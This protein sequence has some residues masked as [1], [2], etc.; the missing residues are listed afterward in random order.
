[1]RGVRAH[2]PLGKSGLR[3]CTAHLLPAPMS[4]AAILQG[5]PRVESDP[6]GDAAHT[7]VPDQP[8]RRA[9]RR[10]SAP[11]LSVGRAFGVGFR[12]GKRSLTRFSDHFPLRTGRNV[13][14]QWG[15]IPGINRAFSKRPRRSRRLPSLWVLW[16]AVEARHPGRRALQFLR[17]L[18]E[19]F[20]SRHGPPCRHIVHRSFQERQALGEIRLLRER[21]VGF[22]AQ[23]D[24]I[25]LP[26][27][28]DEDRAATR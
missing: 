23:K 28:R 25:G 21:V 14:A 7:F 16:V 13:G 12:A 24:A 1:M 6:C 19:A 26:V 17:D 2:F 11:G 27:V 4:Y 18:A 10:T 15:R 3:T 8:S 20:L 5:L 22:R 9:F